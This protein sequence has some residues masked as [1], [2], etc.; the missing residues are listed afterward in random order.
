MQDKK[1][2]KIKKHYDI[3]IDGNKFKIL[4]FI[5]SDNTL[6]LLTKIKGQPFPCGNVVCVLISADGQEVDLK[7]KFKHAALSPILEDWRYEI[8]DE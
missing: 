6:R 2:E 8:V 4:N 5:L 7:C 3:Y 1:S